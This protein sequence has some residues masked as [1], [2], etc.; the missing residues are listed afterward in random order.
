MASVEVAAN[1]REMALD[2][3]IIRCGCGEPA[4]HL[5]AV[6]PRPRAVEDQGTIAFTSRNPLRRLQW[7]LSRLGRG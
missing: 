1:V 7:R 2:A 6:C 4:S 3:V 5:E